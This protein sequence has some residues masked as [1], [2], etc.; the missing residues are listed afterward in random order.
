MLSVLLLGLAC[1]KRD[2][3]V[4][5]VCE[6]RGG[7]PGYVQGLVSDAT[8]GRP[9]V[10]AELEVWGTECRS[11]TDVS[12]MYQIIHVPAG[13]YTVTASYTGYAPRRA[14]VVAEPEQSTRANSRLEPKYIFNPRIGD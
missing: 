8:T 14:L 11:S 1:V 2:V 9:L 6:P 5:L 12:G 4:P 13:R 3:V 10:G 7:E